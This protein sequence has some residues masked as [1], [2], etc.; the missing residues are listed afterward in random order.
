MAGAPV[1]G[2]RGPHA[3]RQDDQ[4][5]LL[6]GLGRAEEAL[7][8]L[9]AG[10]GHLRRPLCR[11]WSRAAA[12]GSAALVVCGVW[13]GAHVGFARTIHRFRR[14]QIISA[15]PWGQ[16]QQ[17]QPPEPPLMTFYMYRASAVDE[18]GKYPFGNINTGNMDGVIWYL[19]NEVVTMYTAGTRCPRKFNI[20]VIHRFKIQVK[21]TP[22]LFKEG[23]N[24]G[25][26]YAYDKGRCMGRC[27]PNNLCTGEGD[28]QFHYDKYGYTLGCNNFYDKYPFPDKPTPAQ[29][30]IWYTLP[31]GG[32]CARPTGAHDCTWSYEY[33]GNLS[34][35]ELESVVPG[36]GNCCHGHCTGFWDDQ[37]NTWRTSQRV[38]Q[39][40]TA[41]AKKYPWTPRDVGPAKCDFQWWKWYSP[42]RWEHR[43]PWAKENKSDETQKTV[44]DG[45]VAVVAN[46]QA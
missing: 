15:A 38:D 16:Q 13:S 18:L 34:L 42:D 39:A 30:G 28:C 10:Q 45:N 9:T 23:M 29:H 32:R 37:F 35:L 1:P 6:G 8:R 3:L 21:S 14:G 19:M 44:D 5:G 27:F 22:E 41:F 26:R 36:Q 40:L 31:L 20:S 2:W 12:L 43:D 4:A 17:W 24:F 25:P 11:F 7:P 33:A 46:G